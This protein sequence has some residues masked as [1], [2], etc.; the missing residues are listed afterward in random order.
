[1]LRGGTVAFRR[2]TYSVLAL[3]SDCKILEASGVGFL[4]HFLGLNYRVGEICVK[5]VEAVLGRFM[6]IAHYLD[7]S[8]QTN[9]FTKQF[10]PRRGNNV[11][12]CEQ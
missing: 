8:D 9:Y 6:L 11:L 12:E 3:R 1:M 7:L 2:W 5:A 4:G 10:L